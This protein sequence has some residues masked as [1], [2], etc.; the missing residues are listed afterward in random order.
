LTSLIINYVNLTSGSRFQFLLPLKAVNDVVAHF[1][2]ND[3]LA[4]ITYCL[5]SK[6]N[7]ALLFIKFKVLFSLTKYAAP[8]R[9]SI[10][11]YKYLE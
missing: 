6:L 11:I 1:H 4:F 8:F 3:V 7:I 10:E 5:L 9:L 2:V